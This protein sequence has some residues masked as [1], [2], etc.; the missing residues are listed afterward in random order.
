MQDFNRREV[1]GT[2]AGVA[3]G[4]AIAAG[5][6]SA[7]ASEQKDAIPVFRFAM[8]DQ[9]GKVTE[10]GSAKEATVHQLPISKGLAG[11]SMRLKPGGLRELHWH[12]IAAEWA[13]M[14]KGRVRT[15]VI[16]PDSTCETN[17][18]GPG[19]VW[20][21]P[22]GH[23][24]A[25]QGLG[26]DESHFILVFDNGA[27]SEHGTFSTTDWLGHT[28]PGVLAKSLGLPEAA[29]AKFPRTE[30]YIPLG[31]IPP[32]QPEPIRGK[33]LKPSPQTHRYALMAHEP[34]AQFSGGTERR[35]TVK[36]FP[37]ATTISAVVLDLNPGAIREP[38]WHPN[39][40]EWFYLLNG[41]L[42]V[43]LFGSGGRVRVEEFTKGD[44][45]Y[46]PQGFGHYVENSG[47]EPCRIL[48]AFDNGDYQEISLSTWLAANPTKMVADNFKISDELVDKLPNHRV[49]V[50]SKDGPG[51]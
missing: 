14:V 38:H 40:N 28:S 39:A 33:G 15:T 8:E 22:R 16:G 25:I 36:E 6:P 2:I 37:I 3:G 30:L 12:A 46:V 11:V 41:R 21:F 34:Y 51:K 5:V 50:A 9:T 1:L 24:H 47:D 18:F 4:M 32:E 17:D 10:G 23:G 42:R 43:G 49:F 45:G 20:Y 19:D 27:F 35:V 31:R 44:A 48:V 26:P 29:F 7:P 13:F